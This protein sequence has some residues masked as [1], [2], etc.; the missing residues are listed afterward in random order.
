ME[1]IT[2]VIKKAGFKIVKAWNDLSG[3]PYKEGGDWIAIIASKR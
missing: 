1:S 2:P 3:T